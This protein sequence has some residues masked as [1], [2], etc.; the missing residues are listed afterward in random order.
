MSENCSF[1]ESKEV[2]KEKEN[3]D[4]TT[5][6]KQKRQRKIGKIMSKRRA[7]VQKRRAEIDISEEEFQS[8]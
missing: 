8:I 5:V 3:V 7:K 6:K 4:S 2:R 1:F